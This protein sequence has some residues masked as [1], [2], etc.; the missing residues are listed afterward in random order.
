MSLSSSRKLLFYTWKFVLKYTQISTIQTSITIKCST[1]W[2]ITGARMF[3]FLTDWVIWSKLD[4]VSGYITSI[5]SNISRISFCFSYEFDSKAR[6]E[7]L[8]FICKPEY[9]KLWQPNVSSVNLVEILH[10][11]SSFKWFKEQSAIWNNNIYGAPF[12]QRLT[13]YGFCFTFNIIDFSDLF[14]MNE[15]I[16]K[17]LKCIMEIENSTEICNEE[18]LR[19]Q[20]YRRFHLWPQYYTVQIW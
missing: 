15:W 19:F 4:L 3:Q 13:P 6:F 10:E 16:T 7:A 11:I 2:K 5:S 17:S 9:L 20:G 14:N 12:V 8:S 18:L 1:C